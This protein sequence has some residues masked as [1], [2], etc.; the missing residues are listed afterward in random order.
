[1]KVLFVEE[2][3]YKWNGSRWAAL[4]DGGSDPTHNYTTAWFISV[5]RRH[6]HTAAA[7]IRPCRNCVACDARRFLKHRMLINAPTSSSVGHKLASLFYRQLRRATPSAEATT[8]AAGAH[9]GQDVL[10]TTTDDYRSSIGWVWC[11]CH[12]HVRASRAFLVER[13]CR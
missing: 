2:K 6:P 3:M 12:P 8:G 13:W 9:T 7:A 10:P 11:G 4:C 1:M 5:W